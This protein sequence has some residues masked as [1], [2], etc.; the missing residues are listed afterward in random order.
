MLSFG[1]AHDSK[2]RCGEMSHAPRQE[3]DDDGPTVSTFRD[4]FDLFRYGQQPVICISLVGSGIIR[5]K[6]LF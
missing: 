5:T 2:S 1:L 6:L 3:I 4:Q